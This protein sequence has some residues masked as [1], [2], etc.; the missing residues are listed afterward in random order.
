MDDAVGPTPPHPDPLLRGERGKKVPRWVMPFIRALERTGQVRE[1]A[2]D[3]G[4]DWSTAYQRRKAHAEFAAAWDDALKAHGEGVAEEEAASIGFVASNPLSRLAR[5]ESDLSPQGRVGVGPQVKRI[6]AERWGRRKEELFFAELAATANVTRAAAAA[7]V[8][9]QAVY[10]R[11]LK[12]ALFRA[13]WE[14]V[15]RTA[16]SAIDLYLVEEA[17]KTFEPEACGL[18]VPASPS[19]SID[20][21]IK[22]AQLNSRIKGD[23]EAFSD[24]FAEQAA[25]MTEDDVQA[26]RDRVLLKLE[27][28]AQRR[29]AEK[30]EAGWQFDEEHDALAPP[31]WVRRCP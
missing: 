4:I 24:P 16:R 1:A 8:S 5:G 19:V 6:G 21:A 30:I 20:Q 28:L 12:H 7:G 18:I 23:G 17:K 11:R 27:R 22:I 14:A 2:K 13:K 25:L 29:I 15:V 9:T 10:N 26:L 3:V 31:G